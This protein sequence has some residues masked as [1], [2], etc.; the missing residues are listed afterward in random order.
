MAASRTLP[1]GP[2]LTILDRKRSGLT[3][4]TLWYACNSIGVILRDTFWYMNIM[5]HE[6]SWSYLYHRAYFGLAYGQLRKGLLLQIKID[7]CGTPGNFS[8]FLL[9]YQC[10]YWKFW[11]NW[12]K[13]WTLSFK[14]WK[15]P[16]SSD[17]NWHTATHNRK[18]VKSPES[19]EKHVNYILS[20]T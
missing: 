1:R 2:R 3:I 16:L 14:F 9:K 17:K 15:T 11:W 13:L 20:F 4:N 6:N 12:N 8:C 10:V 5:V 7:P 19:K 18:N